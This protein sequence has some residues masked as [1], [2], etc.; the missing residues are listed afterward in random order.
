[1]MLFGLINALA[2]FQRAI[3]IALRGCEKFVVV[4]LDGILIFSSS[5]KEHLSHLQRVFEYFD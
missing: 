2:I 4:Y 3:S 1:M 5:R